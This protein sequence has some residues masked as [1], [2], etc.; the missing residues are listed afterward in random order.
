MKSHI[1][2]LVNV[3]NLTQVLEGNIHIPHSC[4]FSVEGAS[5]H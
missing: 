3:I 4:K 5:I 2:T 1:S